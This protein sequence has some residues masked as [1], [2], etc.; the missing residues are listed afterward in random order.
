MAK[1]YSR[2]NLFK[3]IEKEI[4]HLNPPLNPSEK[5]IHFILNYSKSLSVKTSKKL[6]VLFVS[7]N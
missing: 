5:S 4:K 1:N 2:E 3:H 7:L 6:G